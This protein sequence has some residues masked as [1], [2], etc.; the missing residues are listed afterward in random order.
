MRSTGRL[1]RL[2][3]DSIKDMRNDPIAVTRAAAEMLKFNYRLLGS[4]PLAITAY[5]HGPQGVA[6][7]VKEL[8][9]TDI[10]EIVWTTLHRR[11]GFAS[12]NFYA[13]FLAALEVESHAAKYLGKLQVSP[14]LEYDEVQ[15]PRPM[16]F[17]ELALA[18]MKNQKEDGIEKAR[19]YNPFFT[20]AVL[21]G[22]RVIEA[23]YT[24][25]VPKNFK[26]TFLAQAEKINPADAKRL[27]VKSGV[28]KIL[29][30]DTISTISRDFGISIKEL[31]Q[32]NNLQSRTLLHPGQNIVIP[33]L[34]NQ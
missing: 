24:I 12:E 19:L 2:K 11:F 20:R 32:A 28:Y 30:G 33:T 22:H 34:E 1:Y 16:R 27:E 5:N 26:D 10:N 25:R 9:T 15:L 17:G 23:G 14:P 18:I 31:L 3:I 29:P 13:E 6:R 8:K 21:S 7:I 4:W